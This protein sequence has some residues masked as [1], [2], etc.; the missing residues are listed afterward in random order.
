AYI[1]QYWKAANPNPLLPEN[2]WLLDVLKRRAYARENFPA[3]E[4]PY[5][6]E[7]GE[8]YLKYGKPS[9]RYEDFGDL[10][11][12]PN[13]TWAYENIRRDFLV[14]FVKAGAVFR[15]TD[16]LLSILITG[17]SVDPVK[18]AGQWGEIIKKRAAASPALAKAWDAMSA[19]GTRFDKTPYEI[20]LEYEHIVLKARSNTP[21]TAHDPIQTVNRLA[22]S[23]AIAQFRGPNNTTRLE[24]ALLAPLKKNLL[25]KIARDSRDTLK[26]LYRCLLRDRQFE[27]VAEDRMM[28]EF[29]VKLA[30][31]SSLSSAVG[32][33]TV[34]TL[35]PVSEL[36]VQLKDLTQD[37][38]GF[39]RQEV[40]VRDFRGGSLML[41]DIQFL[42]EVAS[43]NQRQ[44]LPAF[45]KLNTAVAPYPF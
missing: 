2:D 3:P 37:E 11:T 41:S 16:D 13:E 8:Y 44:I 1:E 15:K 5:F 7:R 20:M 29:P 24:I 4:P 40:N 25:K 33:L 43:T 32:R 38:I 12:F 10:N 21:P 30:A 18:R 35:P 42:T 23:H 39:T 14:H 9:F 36:T 27:P 19:T 17:K 34:T 31:L 22:F 26:L 45:T 6:D 28:R